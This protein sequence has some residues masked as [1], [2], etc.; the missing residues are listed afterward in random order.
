MRRILIGVLGVLAFAP[1][2]W[3]QDEPPA[4]PEAKGLFHRAISQSGGSFGPT[5]FTTYPGEN[6]R[7]LAQAEASGVAFV[8]KAG[9]S[10]IAEVTSTSGG[11]GMVIRRGAG[12]YYVNGILARWPKAALSLRDAETEA[13]HNEGDLIVRNIL[14][15]ETGATAGTNGPLFESGTGRFV[16]DSVGEN[17]IK[18]ADAALTTDELLG[19]PATPALAGLD[20]SLTTAAAART[21]GTGALSG[22]LATKGGTFIT[23]TDYR[24]AWDPAGAKWWAGWTNYATN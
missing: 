24:G 6:M 20:F 1:A 14:A 16:I 9:V 3:A 15:V 5:R 4:S 22:A 11:V 10:S 21:G 2:S 7:T 19:I 12:G 18:A 17:L 8:Q 23:G 13:R